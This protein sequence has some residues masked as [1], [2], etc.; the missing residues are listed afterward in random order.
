MAATTVDALPPAV[1][2]RIR[3]QLGAIAAEMVTEIQA[4]IPEYARPLD[5]AYARTVEVGVAT[6]LGHFLDLLEQGAPRRPDWRELFATIGAGELREGRSLDTLQAAMRLCARLGW[7]RLVEVA[8][9]EG[10]PLPAV[11]ALAEIIFS[12]LDEIAEA[13]AE[14][15]ARAQAAE[16]GEL[17]RRRRRLLELL[18]AQPPVPAG[19]LAAAARAAR[20]PVPA[21]L[22]A[23]AVA[24]PAA[25]PAERP[26][27]A[28]SAE[29]P[30]LAPDILVGF[31]RPQPCLVVPEPDRPGQRRALAG[32]LAG[33]LAAVGVPVAAGEAAASLRWAR[34]ALHLAERGVLPATELVWCA[35]HLATLAVFQD[36]R[37][38][39]VLAERRLAPL[40]GLRTGPRRLLADTLLTWLQLDKNASEVAARLH[41]HPQTVRYRLR[42]LD[43]LFGPALRDPTQRFELELALRAERALSPALSP[44]DKPGPA[45]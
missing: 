29:V 37:L 24:A 10:A 3:A 14:G 2:A 8:E 31:E 19:T 18:L 42:Q 30:V 1:A 33:R 22:A 23:V 15:Y 7:R 25:Q 4:R 38:L 21:R 44:P 5:P 39:A 32:G 40:S 27:P 28:L 12:Y 45:R 26:Q 9:A 35:E 43:R 6:A 16:A 13:S 41:V 20:W 11:G 36:E 34:Q 17:V